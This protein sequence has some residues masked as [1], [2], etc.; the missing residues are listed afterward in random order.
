MALNQRA[1]GTRRIDQKADAH[2]SGDGVIRESNQLCVHA[3]DDAGDAGDA[4]AGPRIAREEIGKV[5]A[6][7]RADDGQVGRECLRCT[8]RA[9]LA[10]KH[11]VRRERDEFACER[12]Q[13]F[14]IPLGIPIVDVER[15]PRNVS[16]LA[17][18]GDKGGNSAPF[19]LRREQRE[20]GD[21]GP[22]P[23][24][25]RRERPRDSRAAEQRDE[26]AAIHVAPVAQDRFDIA[27]FLLGLTSRYCLPANTIVTGLAFLITWP[28][29]ASSPDVA[30]TRNVTTVSPCSLAA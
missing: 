3:F 27:N 4:A 10:G 18:A 20:H 23:G 25:P 8:S 21:V 29:G 26:L 24:C 13:T 6:K 14:G 17:H 9:R 1:I 7:D 19:V 12:L 22:L 28:V 30:S 16:Q 5:V 11:H 2:Q 15:L